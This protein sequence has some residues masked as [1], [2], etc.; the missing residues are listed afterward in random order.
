MHSRIPSITLDRETGYIISEKGFA[1]D[2]NMGYISGSELALRDQ[3]KSRGLHF[4]S[5][6]ISSKGRL[7]QESMA[8]SFLDEAE[9]GLVKEFM[10][11]DR[12]DLNSSR[13]WNIP[14]ELSSMARRYESYEEARMLGESTDIIEDHEDLSEMVSE[15]LRTVSNIIESLRRGIKSNLKNH[16]KVDTDQACYE[17]LAGLID[18]KKKLQYCKRNLYDSKLLAVTESSEILS[19]NWFSDIADAAG[20]QAKDLVGQGY[21]VV[22]D[23]VKKAKQTASDVT[24]KVVKKVKDTFGSVTDMVIKVGKSALRQ[25]ARFVLRIIVT[26]LVVGGSVIKD[27]INGKMNFWEM[28]GGLTIFTAI[29]LPYA[30]MPMVSGVIAS[31]LSMGESLLPDWLAKLIHRADSITDDVVNKIEDLL[32]VIIKWLGEV[33]KSM[34]DSPSH[35]IHSII[36]IIA[37]ILQLAGPATAGLS[38]LLAMGI[39]IIHGVSYFI[40]SMFTDDEDHKWEC[41]LVGSVTLVLGALGLHSALVGAKAGLRAGAKTIAKYATENGGKISMKVVRSVIKDVFGESVGKVMKGMLEFIK[42]PVTLIKSMYKKIVSSK[43]GKFMFSRLGGK[44]AMKGVEKQGSK[45]MSHNSKIFAKELAQEEAELVGKKVTKSTAAKA[46]GVA[47][48]AVGIGMAGLVAYDMLSSVIGESF[49]AMMLLEKKFGFEK[50]GESFDV[51]GFSKYFSKKLGLEDFDFSPKGIKSRTDRYLGKLINDEALSG[52][53]GYAKMAKEYV[54]DAKDQIRSIKR[55]GPD[56][57][58]SVIDNIIN[59]VKFGFNRKTIYDNISK[60]IAQGLKNGEIKKDD[61]VKKRMSYVKRKTGISDDLLKHHR[62]EDEVNNLLKTNK[63]RT[64]SAKAAR[65]VR[66]TELPDYKP[67]SISSYGLPKGAVKKDLLNNETY[68]NRVSG[69]ISKAAKNMVTGPW[70]L[71]KKIFK[72]MLIFIL[73][74][75]AMYTLI[76]FGIVPLLNYYSEEEDDIDSILNDDTETGGDNTDDE[77]DVD[78]Q[79]S[80]SKTDIMQQVKIHRDDCEEFYNDVKQQSDKIEDLSIEE[81][82]E[83]YDQWI[84]LVQ[85]NDMIKEAI[86]DNGLSGKKEDA[87]CDEARDFLDMTEKMLKGQ[88]PSIEDPEPIKKQ[89]V[90]EFDQ[91]DLANDVQLIISGRVSKPKDD[92][93]PRL[94]IKRV[95]S[96]QDESEA[97]E[98]EGLELVEEDMSDPSVKHVF[99]LIY[100]SIGD[101]DGYEEKDD[102]K[103][104]MIGSPKEPIIEKF[105]S[106]GWQGK[107]LH[108]FFVMR[109]RRTVTLKKKRFNFRRNFRSLCKEEP[110]SEWKINNLEDRGRKKKDTLFFCYKLVGEKE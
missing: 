86:E 31:L 94:T 74:M 108:Y 57:I 32:T 62:L 19:E 68:F 93:E 39:E 58:R 48:D 29:V 13:L 54:K 16:D 75:L 77:D 36:D 14:D 104:I 89:E 25:G 84:K 99:D 60:T 12:T 100:D 69:K 26:P 2:P 15:D 53:S 61:S 24:N 55:A 22:K 72:V 42:S 46:S 103:W 66:I 6:G 47:Q 105:K 50:P 38:V 41:W 91:T 95:L 40:E 67:V 102:W 8:H 81:A 88:D 7:L 23:T 98:I 21:S 3:L 73:I 87:L 65:S 90:E 78:V 109:N 80:I 9:L 17:M 107:S 97:E 4:T 30:G 110:S 52:K 33:P 11:N 96:D 56:D 70:R 85:V 28:F 64:L 59:D 101:E 37:L 5:E 10:Y 76:R 34:F 45:M 79:T 83:L 35:S 1:I 43:F 51:D 20:K 92:E 82:Q 106:E 27:M 49:E 44:E 63:P 18:V 71:I